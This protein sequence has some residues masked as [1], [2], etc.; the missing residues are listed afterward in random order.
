MRRVN[1]LDKFVATFLGSYKQ[2]VD[3][4]RLA[5]RNR[6]TDEHYKNQVALAQDELQRKD[7]QTDALINH[8]SAMESIARTR[9]DGAAGGMSPQ[10]MD[11]MNN[12]T[13]RTPDA[14]TSINT[15]TGAPP[16]T[17]QNLIDMPMHATGGV[18]EHPLHHVLGQAL[19]HIQN[20]YALH[21]ATGG[22]IPDANS[23]QQL[24][25][26]HSNAGAVSPQALDALMSQTG[27]PDA[28]ISQI[29]N[30]YAARGKP[31]IADQAASGVLQGLRARSME[32]GA[33]AQAAHAQGDYPTAAQ[34]ISDAYRHIPDAHT[35]TAKVDPRGM[36]EGAFV[37]GQGQPIE[38]VP[39]NPDVLGR[40][41]QTFA[42]G[43]GF[44]PHIAQSMQK[45]VKK[46]YGAGLVDDEGIDTDAEDM[47]AIGGPSPRSFAEGAS[48]S[49]L[50][51]GPEEQGTQV[52]QAAIPASSTS[53]AAM[54]PY[55]PWMNKVDRH[56][57]DME[58]KRRNSLERLNQR[59][60]N[61]VGNMEMQANLRNPE[62]V[63]N[64]DVTSLNE[65]I[66][67][68]KDTD[69]EGL[70]YALMDKQAA[71]KAARAAK[72]TADERDPA[73]IA[74]NRKKAIEYWQN[75]SKQDLNAPRRSDGSPMTNVKDKTFYNFD[76]LP[77]VQSR[78]EEVLYKLLPL[79]QDEHS[80]ERIVK[81]AH[82]IA[83]NKNFKPQFKDGRVLAGGDEFVMPSNR[84]KQLIALRKDA[85]ALDAQAAANAEKIK[86]EA[87][88]KPQQR[89]EALSMKPSEYSADQQYAIQYGLPPNTSPEEVD[90]KR[91]FG[92]F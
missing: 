88:A 80:P 79:N 70:M 40:S 87:A 53:D 75:M 7:K 85:K 92:A 12:Y 57:V 37:N 5:E 23:R 2:S 32:A 29:Y 47:A 69:R 35:F 46:F 34:H 83:F 13:P 58:N 18:V 90:R 17:E 62:W 73:N 41:A 49:P 44:Y 61:T 25:M 86:Q 38:R 27:S 82:D 22:A 21:A 56:Y 64:R 91:Q 9:A 81:V 8:W 54:I 72:T 68:A 26:F 36:G 77:D 14:N 6:I 30:F 74:E 55:Q 89:A 16:A 43:S 28:A 66:A 65:Q 24:D 20:S 31:E 3:D 15:P 45:P 78:F 63:H 48:L 19:N 76:G 4:A 11:Y 67:K 52:A 59:Q 33:R 60:D 10:L 71:Y 84:W 1:D 39:I 42:N 50:G 51:N